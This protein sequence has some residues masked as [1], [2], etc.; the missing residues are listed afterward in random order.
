[1][2]LPMYGGVGPGGEMRTR[3]PISEENSKVGPMTRSIK[4]SV[5]QNSIHVFYRQGPILPMTVFVVLIVAQHDCCKSFPFHDTNGWNQYCGLDWYAMWT[6]TLWT[7]SIL[8]KGLLFWLF[9]QPTVA[10]AVFYCQI[11]LC[12]ACFAV[13]Q[14]KRLPFVN[15]HGD[16]AQL[17]VFRQQKRSLCCSYNSWPTFP[18]FENRILFGWVLTELFDKTLDVREFSILESYTCFSMLHVLFL[19]FL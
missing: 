12:F 8:N 9:F 3:C 14:L 7:K 19:D 15:V 11:V 1:M 13:L 16:N 4:Q 10:G 2:S 17:N 6:R 5:P 18:Y